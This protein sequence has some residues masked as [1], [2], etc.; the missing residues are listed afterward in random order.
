M[1]IRNLYPVKTIKIKT[2]RKQR[3]DL[4]REMQVLPYQCKC[5][6]QYLVNCHT[7]RKIKP[8]LV[9]VLSFKEHTYTWLPDNCHYERWKMSTMKTST[10]FKG[11][12][13]QFNSWLFLFSIHLQLIKVIFSNFNKKTAYSS[14]IMSTPFYQIRFLFHY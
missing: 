2:E 1:Y 14:I 4:P 3:Q 12:R 11:V 6:V 7:P 9:V 13:C 5:K 8:I 10:H